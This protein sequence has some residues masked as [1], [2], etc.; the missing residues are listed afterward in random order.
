MSDDGRVDFTFFVTAEERALWQEAADQAGLSVE[1][2]I[3]RAVDGV[4]RRNQIARR[5]GME[6]RRG[7]WPGL[8]D[9]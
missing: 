9:K 3:I 6:A 5:V 1:D 4:A 7:W 8:V 2:W